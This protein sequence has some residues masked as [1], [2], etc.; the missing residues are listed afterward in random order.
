MR[1]NEIKPKE[2][3]VTLSSDELVLLGNLMYFYEKNHKMDPDTSAP[4]PLFYN[5]AQQ[6]VIA[7][8]LCQYG[9]LDNFCLESIV[10]YNVAVNPE[11]RMVSMKNALGLMNRAEYPQAKADQATK[12]EK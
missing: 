6:V 8:D 1:I 12:G 11:S 2:V 10:R 7:R 4:G 5:M 9:H 3:N